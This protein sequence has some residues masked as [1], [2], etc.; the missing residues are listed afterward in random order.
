M[1]SSSSAPCNFLHSHT[2]AARGPGLAEL[3]HPDITALSTQLLDCWPVPL[4]PGAGLRHYT[5]LFR[6]S[7]PSRRGMSLPYG[8]GSA[9]SDA[10]SRKAP[11]AGSTGVFEILCSLP[12]AAAP[13]ALPLLWG[14]G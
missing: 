14:N 8:S 10:V 6:S 12:A 1:F 2:S 7:A 13:V 11:A 3:A 9:A 4:L 5:W